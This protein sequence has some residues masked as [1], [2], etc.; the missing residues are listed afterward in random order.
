MILMAVIF[1]REN[2]P[3]PV[4][5]S[6]DYPTSSHIGLIGCL[7]VIEKRLPSSYIHSCHS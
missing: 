3:W 2:V 6:V 7:T 5:Q 4:S 1:T